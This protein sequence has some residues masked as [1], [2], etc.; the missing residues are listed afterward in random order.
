[1]E[2]IWLEVCMYEK[3]YGM[4]VSLVLLHAVCLLSAC[5][6][7]VFVFHRTS[8]QQTYLVHGGTA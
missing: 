4:C 8:L 1:M 3:E 6:H 2:V 7:G 5:L